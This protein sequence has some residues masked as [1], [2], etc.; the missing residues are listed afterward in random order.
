MIY[1]R[2][3]Q[4]NRSPSTNPRHSLRTFLSTSY[5][6]LFVFQGGFPEGYLVQHMTPTAPDSRSPHFCSTGSLGVTWALEKNLWLFRLYR[7]LYYPLHIGTTINHYRD[8]YLPTRIQWKV[9]HGTGIFTGYIYRLP[10]KSTK[11]RVLNIPVPWI[12]WEYYGIGLFHP[13][14]NLNFQPRIRVTSHHL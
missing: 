14:Y 3:C 13:T 8:P 9:R 4:T 5:S 6:C 10:H 2:I 11:C 7:G 1:H 12:L